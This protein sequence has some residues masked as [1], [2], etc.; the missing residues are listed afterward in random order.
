MGPLEATF[1]HGEE[2][3]GLWL[4]RGQIRRAEVGFGGFEAWTERVYAEEQ[5]A[6]E[7]LDA[8]LA[9]ELHW[10]Q[11]GVTAR[12]KRNQGRLAKLG[13]MREARAA[14]IGGPG[15]SKLGLARDDSKTKVVIDAEQVTK[16]FGERA[17]STNAAHDPPPIGRDRDGGTG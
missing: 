9:I 11:R 4:D 2:G 1:D 15:V 17:I 16:R 12:R 3:Y 10:L 14:M 6:A 13:E 8:K 5:R 7:K